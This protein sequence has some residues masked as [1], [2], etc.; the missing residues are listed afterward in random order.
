MKKRKNIIFL[1]L[2]SMLV[3]LFLVILALASYT[4]IPNPGHGADK[5]FVKI[6]NE[7]K[8]IQDLMNSDSFKNCDLSIDADFSSIIHGH[9]A[10]EIIVNVAGVTKTL[11]QAIQDKSLLQ[12]NNIGT[13]PASYG[14]ITL[15]QY[16]TADKIIIKDKLGNEKTLQS[17]INNGDFNC[18]VSGCQPQPSTG[19]SLYSF[20]RQYSTF[21]ISPYVYII[22]NSLVDS[23][24]DRTGVSYYTTQDWLPENTYTTTLKLN[25]QGSY[26]SNGKDPR[27]E[28]II[29]YRIY[30]NTK[31]SIQTDTFGEGPQLNRLDTIQKKSGFNN[32]ILVNGIEKTIEA[33]KYYEVDTKSWNPGGS[34]N[35]LTYLRVH[36]PLCQNYVEVE[37]YVYEYDEEYDTA[38]AGIRSYIEPS[39]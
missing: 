4:S 18:L 12:V 21:G 36:N 19:Y 2:L 22:S 10:N 16:H 32:I 31:V 26:T 37:Q 17:A 38:S 28:Y 1:A 9:N 7:N 30:G 39:S 27:T 34:G 13:S 3:L 24:A 33:E 15:I 8:D 14:S 23:T 20:Q 29:K 6:S 25:A 5:I 11:A 35:G